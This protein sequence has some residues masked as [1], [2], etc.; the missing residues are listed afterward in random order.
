MSEVGMSFQNLRFD[1]IMCGLLHVDD[2]LVWSGI[3]CCECLFKIVVSIFPND[4]GLEVDE[5]GSIIRFLSSVLIFHE[6]AS[7]DI[8]PYPPNMC[9][10]LGV[11]EHQVRSV[12]LRFE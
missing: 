8:F 3:W 2:G 12:Q 9:F 1:Q 10:A 11:S 5:S 6:D 4:V 7:F